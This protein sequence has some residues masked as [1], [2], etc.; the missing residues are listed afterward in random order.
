[1]DIKKLYKYP[2]N[3][4]ITDMDTSTGHIFIQQVPVSY[5]PCLHP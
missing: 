3:E 1:M 4:Y 5:P 2:H